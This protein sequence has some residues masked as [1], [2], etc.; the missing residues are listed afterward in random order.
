MAI[1]GSVLPYLYFKRFINDDKTRKLMY[2]PHL[3]I[4]TA[5]Q[6]YIACERQL[7]TKACTSEDEVALIL[8]EKESKFK[9]MEAAFNENKSLF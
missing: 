5:Y 4:V 9:E 8:S 3:F 1:L 7:R 6:Q 2:Q